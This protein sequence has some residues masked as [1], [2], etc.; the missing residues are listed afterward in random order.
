MTQFAQR[1]VVD[2]HLEPLSEAETGHCISSS[3]KDCRRHPALFTHK[4]CCVGA[5]VDERVF[6]VLI[7]QICDIALT[8]G[9]T[10]QAR[11]I[12]CKACCSGGH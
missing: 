9:F 2:H 10:E 8:Y 12:T 7:N 11:F 1:I 5:S 3:V 4:A 6:R